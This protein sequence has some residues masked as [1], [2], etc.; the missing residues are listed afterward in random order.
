MNEILNTAIAV[1]AMISGT[2]ALIVF[3]RGDRF[4][5]PALRSASRVQQLLAED[6]RVTAVLSQLTEN[7]QVHP[8]QR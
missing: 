4:A 8:A 2:V 3:V 6:V 1:L 5:G 7:V